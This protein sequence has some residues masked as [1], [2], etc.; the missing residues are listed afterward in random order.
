MASL[1]DLAHDEFELLARL[2]IGYYEDGLTQEALARRFGLSRPKVQRMLDRARTTGVVDIRISTP[3]WLHVDL[4]RELRE[5]FGLDEVIVA[6]GRT[7]PQAQR[8]E[9]ARAAARYLERTPGR[10]RRGRGEP[11]TGHRRGAALLRP[12]APDR[13]DL[14]ERHG[15]LATRRLADQPQRDRAPP[16]RPVGRPGHGPV[17]AGPRRE[18]ADARRPAAPGRGG[19]D[20]AGG[21]RRVGGAAGDRWHGRRL[22]DGPRAAASPWRRSA[23][24]APRAPWATCSATTW[25]S[26][27]GAWS[28]PETARLVGLVA[29]RA[30]RD[31]HGR[32]GG[33]RGREAARDPRR[34]ADRA[35][36][37]CSSSTRETRASCVEPARE[38]T[39]ASL[40]GGVTCL[41]FRPRR[42]SSGRSTSATASRR[43]TSSTT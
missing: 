34:P 17:R 39:T 21:R 26:R 13:R 41:S 28:R 25:T 3:P 15:R 31:R 43:S 23:G 20:A 8:E 33:Q 16:R 11:R 10:R 42:S 1:D 14:R 22:H 36:W 40:D 7:D 37:T 12:R 29:R 35:S 18:R 6:Q 5:R 2:S 9:V 24:C 27:A 4:E 19:G 30:A 32:G 38:A